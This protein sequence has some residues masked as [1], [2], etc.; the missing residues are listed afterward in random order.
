MPQD[1][2]FPIMTIEQIKSTLKLNI[3]INV[4]NKRKILT[5]PLS[6]QDINYKRLNIPLG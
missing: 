1:T 4:P 2:K 6:F 5:Q 3:Y